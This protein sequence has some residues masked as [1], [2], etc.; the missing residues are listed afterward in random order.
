MDF[1]RHLRSLVPKVE[2]ELS[3]VLGSPFQAASNGIKTFFRK[4]FLR[5]EIGLENKL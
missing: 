3:M 1:K 4:A 2:N 5:A